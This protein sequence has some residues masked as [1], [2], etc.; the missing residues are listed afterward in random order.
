MWEGKLHKHEHGLARPGTSCKLE[1]DTAFF[2]LISSCRVM[3]NMIVAQA[4][5]TSSKCAF[6]ELASDV[7]L[8]KMHY[9]RNVLLEKLLRKLLEKC[10]IWKNILLEERTTW[11]NVLLEMNYLRRTTW[12]NVLLEKGGRECWVVCYKSVRLEHK[13]V[14]SHHTTHSCIHSCRS[15]LGSCCYTTFLLLRIYFYATRLF[16]LLPD[17]EVCQGSLW[18]DALVNTLACFWGVSGFT[19]MRRACLNSCLLLRCVR[20]HFDATRLFKLL[21]AS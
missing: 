16:K 2:N 15:P 7:L 14:E 10:T 17:S 3:K 19:L 6:W 4:Y 20:V 18:C 12:E 21:Q 13:E 11:E 1:L 8:E 5:L 9:L